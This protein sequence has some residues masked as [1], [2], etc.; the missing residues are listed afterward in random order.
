MEIVMRFALALAS[1]A[2]LVAAGGCGETPASAPSP[3]P[4]ATVEPAAAKKGP[5]SVGK[6]TFEKRREYSAV[7]PEGPPSKY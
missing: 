3:K 7:D 6:Q 1:S 4:A 2:L 5:T